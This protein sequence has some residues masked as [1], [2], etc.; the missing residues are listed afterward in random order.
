MQSKL[1]GEGKPGEIVRNLLLEIWEKSNRS[2]LSDPWKPF[3]DDVERLFQCRLLPPEAS[4]VR[5][6]I[7]CEYSPKARSDDVRT[8]APRLDIANAGSGFHQVLLLLSF[9]YAKHAALLLLDEPDAHLHVILQREIFDHLRAVA[10]KRRSQLLIGT[11][12][13]VL[14][15]DTDPSQI[16]SFLS[17]AP[18]R[19]TG[20]TDKRLL[21]DAMRMLTA[22]DLLQL[23]HIGAVLYVEDYSDHKLLREWARNLKHRAYDFLQ[24][25]YVVPMRGRGNVDQAKRHFACLRLVNPK[26]KGTLVLD[27]DEVPPLSH[28]GFPGGLALLQWKRYEIENYLLHPEPILR[29][30]RVKIGELLANPDLQLVR[31]EFAENLPANIDFLGD[32]Q[33]LRDLKGSEFLVNLLAK[34]TEPLAKSELYILAQEMRPEEIHSDIVAALDAIAATLPHVGVID[35]INQSPVDVEGVL[36]EG[37]PEADD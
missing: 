12:A 19:L 14:L 34:T 37:S 20:T 21:R 10:E 30:L 26:V 27:R 31:D 15:E 8:R 1:V 16:L 33:V 17:S 28:S 3:A 4:D 11:H 18:A 36:P 29:Y 32:T 24:F 13:E 9:F 7:L 5:P 35:L 2:E 22:L 23:S 25:A 6:Y